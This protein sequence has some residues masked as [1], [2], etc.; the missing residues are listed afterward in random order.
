MIMLTVI[1]GLIQQQYHQKVLKVMPKLQ[2][3]YKINK[4]TAQRVAEKRAGRKTPPKSTNLKYLTPKSRRRTLPKNHKNL[5]K[6][7]KDLNL[8][9]SVSGGFLPTF[10]TYENYICRLDSQQGAEMN[11]VISQITQ[12]FSEDLDRI[13]NEND[14]GDILKHIWEM[15]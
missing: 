1:Y 5:K 6:C 3:S 7:I 14:K 9:G 10:V 2:Q 13:F 15:M 11:E 12:N 4:T 8:I